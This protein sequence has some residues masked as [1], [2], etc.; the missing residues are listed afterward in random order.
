VNPKLLLPLH[1]ARERFVLD[2]LR[3]LPAPPARVLDVGCGEGHLHP[4]IRPLC[5]ALDA[6][7]SNA[8]DL[9]HAARAAPDT[10]TRRYH[11]ADATALPWDDATFDVVLALELVE[12]V[13][14]PRAVLAELARVL[15]PG[16]TLLLTC[17]SADFPLT[18][19]PLHRLAGRRLAAVGAYAYGHDTLPTEAEVRRWIAAAGLDT[20]RCARLSGA[21]AALTEAYWAG[22]IQRVG[23]ANAGNRA[24]GRRVG[25]RLG[26]RVPPG[27]AL[28]DRLLD[29]DERLSVGR[30]ASV[31]LGFVVTRACP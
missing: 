5:G 31:G 30:R 20:V 9:W 11:V 29:L 24:G 16:G 26:P 23:K 6:C 18:Y 10:P 1:R 17:P 27:V 14:D 28:V 3:A 12:H 4:A 2:A 25:L 19:D 7:D 21:L 8:A 22:A 15:R 13:P